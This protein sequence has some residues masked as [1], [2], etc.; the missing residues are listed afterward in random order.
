MTT[1]GTD[2]GDGRFGHPR[3]PL[4]GDCVVRARHEGRVPAGAAGRLRPSLPTRMNLLVK[5]GRGVEGL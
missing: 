4:T 1:A 2:A 3:R 5:G